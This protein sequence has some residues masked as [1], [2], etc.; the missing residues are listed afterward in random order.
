MGICPIRR[1]SYKTQD[2]RVQVHVRTVPQ[3]AKRCH[4]L[5]S[6][7][8]LLAIQTT[9]QGPSRPQV[10]PPRQGYA[11]RL[12][13]QA[14]LRHLPHRHASRR[15]KKAGR[16]R[17]SLWQTQDF[18][19]RHPIET[20]RN[21]QS[22]AEERVGRRVQGLRVLSSY[23]VGQDSTYKYFEVIM[24]DPF[25]KAIRRDAKINWMCR[26]VM[27]HRELRGLT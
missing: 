18:W 8:P 2:G 4:A 21:L 27:K 3:E 19:C 10:H 25:H 16:Q 7:H 12:Q 5:P 24:I 17:L 23:W 15:P 9:G 26:P 22:I 11:S 6:L 14:R 13:E 20:L 1:A